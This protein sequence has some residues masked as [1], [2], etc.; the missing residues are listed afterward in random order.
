MQWNWVLL[1]RAGEPM[2]VA[3]VIAP[4]QRFP[5]QSDA[6][7]W[8]GEAWPALRDAG[9]EAV[10]LR[11]DERGVYGPMSLHPNR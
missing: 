4:D 3:E 5:S 8:L 2:A 7:T 6:E 10:V 9:V 11:Q 1:D